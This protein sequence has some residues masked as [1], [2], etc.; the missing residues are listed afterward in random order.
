MSSGNSPPPAGR[1]HTHLGGEGSR[2]WRAGRLVHSAR[3]QGRHRQASVDVL[4]CALHHAAG[5]WQVAAN[6]PTA[7]LPSAASANQPPAYCPWPCSPCS[8]SSHPHFSNCLHPSAAAHP[9]SQVQR[10]SH[11]TTGPS[12][13][14]AGP[15]ISGALAARTHHHTPRPPTH[16]VR[17]APAGSRNPPS[18]G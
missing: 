16:T 7:K 8:S 9:P 5:G 12:T 11:S 6:C 15:S 3:H 1:P 10:S 2:G 14:A 4:W 17:G 18:S 13:P